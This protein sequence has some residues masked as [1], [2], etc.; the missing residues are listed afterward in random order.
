M[1]SYIEKIGPGQAKKEI[2]KKFRFEYRFSQPKM[3]HSLKNSK[4]NSKFFLK[5][6]HSEFISSQTEPRQ[7]EKKIK[8]KKFVTSMFLPDL[9]WRISKKIV[10]KS[11]KSFWLH[12]Y[13][14]RVRSLKRENFFFLFRVPFLPNLGWSI[15]KQIQ[16]NIKIIQK[17]KKC[18]SGLISCQTRSGR[19]EKEIK[20]KIV[21]STVSTRPR[22]E[23]SKKIEKKLKKT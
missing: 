9:G 16:K 15:P 3:E 20:K 23:H 21:P 6:C 7:A 5:K 19:E 17:N 10:K 13:I 22:L 4:K 12:F 1:A 11:K 8:K 18:L 2:K 14:N